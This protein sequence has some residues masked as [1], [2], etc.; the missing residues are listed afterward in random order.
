MMITKRRAPYHALRR[1]RLIALCNGFKA[2][3]V[4]IPFQ[5]PA[6]SLRHYCTLCYQLA[7]DLSLHALD[8]AARPGGKHDA[9]YP[10]PASKMGA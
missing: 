10:P 2:H 9:R 1:T 5:P 4:A 8:A 6:D 7:P 3:G